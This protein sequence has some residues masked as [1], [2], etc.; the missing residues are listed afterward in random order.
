MAIQKSVVRS[1]WSEV[2]GQKQPECLIAVI[3]DVR[4]DIYLAHRE[5]A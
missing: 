3:L 1:Q 4:G 2:R 5:A